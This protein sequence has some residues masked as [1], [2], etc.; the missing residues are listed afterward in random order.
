[1]KERDTLNNIVHQLEQR[2]YRGEILGREDARLLCQADLQEVKA[3]ACRVRRFFSGNNLHFRGVISLPKGVPFSV[4]AF[5]REA[6]ILAS[7]GAKRVHI[8]LGRTP[9]SP[10]TLESLCQSIQFLHKHEGI[11][12]GITHANL[13]L[14]EFCQLQNAGCIWYH[15][16]LGLP[17]AKFSQLQSITLPY[18]EKIRLLKL[19]RSAGLEISTGGFFDIGET[20]EDRIQLVLEARELGI[21]GFLVRSPQWRNERRDWIPSITYEEISRTVAVTRFLLPASCIIMEYESNF[22]TDRGRWLLESG[23][24]GILSGI[25]TEPFHIAL[26]EG[27]DLGREMGFVIC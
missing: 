7:H 26:E 27:Q 18:D 21:Y 15:D 1:M 23:A 3:A 4:S 9:L 22:F 2:T 8:H 25:S 16:F 10:A 24:N 13:T 17:R 6:R 19:A 5:E 12:I 20:M 14:Q 11:F